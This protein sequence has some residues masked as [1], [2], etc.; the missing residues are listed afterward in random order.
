MV[1]CNEFRLISGTNILLPPQTIAVVVAESTN[2][3]NSTITKDKFTNITANPLV[4]R[5]PFFVHD[6][7][8]LH[9]S[10][11]GGE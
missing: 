8:H 4:Y 9:M 11:K 10:R 3:D 6:T 7:H 5:E 2:S 1:E